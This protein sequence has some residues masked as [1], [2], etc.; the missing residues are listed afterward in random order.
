MLDGLLDG[1]ARRLRGAGVVGHTVVVRLRF[2][3]F[4]RLTRSSTLPMA[5][6]DT[7]PL[8]EVAQKLLDSARSLVDERG[9]TLIGVAVANLS[10]ADAVQLRL[11]FDQGAGAALDT[12]LDDVRERF[13]SSSVGRAALLGNRPSDWSMPLLPDRR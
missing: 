4:T 12:A 9:L 13:G 10:D 3:D 6:A 5:T 1:V 11:P 8:R 7:Q 2:D